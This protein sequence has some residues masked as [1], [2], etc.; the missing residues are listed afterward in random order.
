[1]KIL[2]KKSLGQN[3]LI[4]QNI[5]NK[6]VDIGKIDENNSV[7]EIGSGYGNLT[8]KIVNMK[9]KKILAVEKDK[10]LTLFL[11][12]LFKDSKNV[13]VICDDIFNVIENKN[14]DEKIIVFGNLP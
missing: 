5:I 4:D 1:M 10:K 2:P 11:K 9:P 14:L 6:I 12:D 13:K 7:L 8:K 3:F